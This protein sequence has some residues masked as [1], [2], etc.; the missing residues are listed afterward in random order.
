MHAEL[1]D[2]VLAIIFLIAAIAFMV[3]FTLGFF[4]APFVPS[5]RKTV[6]KMLR[7]AR[8]QPGMRVVD[9]G[10][11]DGRII[12]RADREYGAI[13]TGYEI[14]IFVALL[15]RI[16]RWLTH[17]M[18][19]IRRESFFH[20]DLTQ[21]DVVFCYLLPEVMK[22]L[23]PKFSKELKSGARIVSAGFSLPGWTPVEDHLRDGSGAIRIYVYEKK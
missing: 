9:L 18:A 8:L 12:C 7:L 11:G 13:A 17:S 20:A 19:E 3:F 16:R 22:K 21:T 6:A 14:S 2:L 15:A 1:V 4:R 5:N 10:C 23:E